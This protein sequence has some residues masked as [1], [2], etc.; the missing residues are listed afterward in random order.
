M[1]ASSENEGVLYFG[2]AS[3]LLRE[4]LALRSP[5]AKLVSIGKIKFVFVIIISKGV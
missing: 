2:Y 1:A 5:S 4:K 3:N